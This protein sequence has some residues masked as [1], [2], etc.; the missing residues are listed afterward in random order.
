MKVQAKPPIPQVESTA[1]STS[2]LSGQVKMRSVFV[3]RVSDTCWVV[4]DD[5]LQRG[6]VFR[7]EKSALTFIRKDIGEDVVVCNLQPSAK[8]SNVCHLDTIFH[9]SPYHL[10]PLQGS[11]NHHK[12]EAT[13][14]REE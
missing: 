12:A 9:R 3:S 5:N 4:S 1:K 6:G 10:E 11:L 14:V 13:D 2:Q 8:G 7:D